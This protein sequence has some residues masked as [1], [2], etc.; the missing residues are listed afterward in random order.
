MTAFQILF[1]I[2]ILGLYALFIVY[3]VWIYQ[4]TKYKLEGRTAVRERVYD[5]HKELL[6]GSK[7]YHVHYFRDVPASQIFSSGILY[8]TSNQVGFFPD[9]DI[10]IPELKLTREQLE[11]EWA[12]TIFKV[13]GFTPWFKIITNGKEHHFRAETGPTIWGTKRATREICETLVRWKHE[14]T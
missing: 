13:T 8:L 10:D 7:W 6:D 2:V 12:G 4:R 3:L 9:P 11:V 1:W 5:T 14:N